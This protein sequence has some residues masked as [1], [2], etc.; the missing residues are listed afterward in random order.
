MC[1]I[2]AEKLQQCFNGVL[3]IT[4]LPNPKLRCPVRENVNRPSPV[5]FFLNKR[6]RGI[7]Q[8]IKIICFTS[9]CICPKYYVTILLNTFEINI[10]EFEDKGSNFGKLLKLDVIQ[11]TK[12]YI[13]QVSNCNLAHFKNPVAILHLFIICLI[14]G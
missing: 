2:G 7:W 3:T 9:R 4:Y 11:I 1:K 10:W 6:H 5:W 8:S 14:Q 12:Y 13:A